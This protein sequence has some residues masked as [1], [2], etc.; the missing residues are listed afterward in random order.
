VNDPLENARRAGAGTEG[1]DPAIIAEQKRLQPRVILRFHA[2]ADSLGV[3]GMMNGPAELAGKPAVVDAP[4]GT[5]HV[6]SF[7]IR[8]LWR[9]ETQGTFAL[10][11]NAIAHWNHLATPPAPDTARRAAA[12]EQQ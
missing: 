5:G 9:Q 7:A 6:V 4:L 12:A 8:P 1:I 2:T 10:A 3:S 11:L